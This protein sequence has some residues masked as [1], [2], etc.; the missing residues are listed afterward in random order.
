MGQ[1]MNT[2][3]T[4]TA[5]RT[6]SAGRLPFLMADCGLLWARKLERN[7]DLMSFRRRLFI[8]M[9]FSCN[10]PLWFSASERRMSAGDYSFSS[11]VLSVIFAT[12][13]SKSL[14]KVL[15]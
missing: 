4:P 11:G 9:S 8:F 14:L 3:Y 7:H 15:S 2:I 13:F 12:S 5:G 1:N 10:A 6:A